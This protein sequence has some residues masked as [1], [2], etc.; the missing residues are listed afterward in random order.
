M[1]IFESQI[2][3]VKYARLHHRDTQSQYHEGYAAEM[4]NGQL[5]RGTT[6]VQKGEVMFDVSCVFSPTGSVQHVNRKLVVE[7]LLW[8]EEQEALVCFELH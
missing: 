6:Q 3:S 1:Q 7:R 4:L 8:L 2:R 5:L